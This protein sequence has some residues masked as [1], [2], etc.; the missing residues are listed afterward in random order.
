MNALKRAIKTM[1]R[2]ELERE[3]SGGYPTNTTDDLL[4]RA[5]TYALI[6]IAQEQRVISNQPI[7]HTED[8]DYQA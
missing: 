6:A 4:V 7:D 3:K 2:Y 1:E 8:A 5:Q